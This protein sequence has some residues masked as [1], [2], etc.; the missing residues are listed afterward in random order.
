[1]C[2]GYPARVLEVDAEGATVEDRGRRRRAST[3]FLPSV[4][5][6]DWVLVAA[7][8]I[9][10]HLDPED[11]ADLTAQLARAEAHSATVDPST[12]HVQ[13]PGSQGGQS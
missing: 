3:L 7:G 2:L 13:P 11:A 9:V 8:S 6:G 4:G 10:R 12:R 5:P 1:M